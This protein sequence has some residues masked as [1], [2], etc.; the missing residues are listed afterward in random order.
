MCW[1]ADKDDAGWID[2]T[3]RR[4]ATARGGDANMVQIVVARCGGSV[5]A[6]E[7]WY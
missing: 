1:H 7:L 2:G 6:T 3:W 5:M 4:G